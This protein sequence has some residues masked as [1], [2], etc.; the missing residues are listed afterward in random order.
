MNLNRVS[1]PPWWPDLTFHEW[2]DLKCPP[3]LRVPL[4]LAA[5]FPEILAGWA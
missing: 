2:P 4:I 3:R 5:S 1:T